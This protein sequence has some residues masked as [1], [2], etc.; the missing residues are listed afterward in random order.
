MPSVN[1]MILTINHAAE[2]MRFAIPDL[3]LVHA[4]Q[5]QFLRITNPV[6]VVRLI[7]DD[8]A[9]AVKMV[10]NFLMM[11][12]LIHI[13]IR[14]I[15]IGVLVL[16]RGHVM[17]LSQQLDCLEVGYAINHDLVVHEAGAVLQVCVHALDA[18]VAAESVVDSDFV[19]YLLNGIVLLLVAGDQI[20]LKQ[21]VPAAQD[22][23]V[24]R[25]EVVPDDQLLLLQL[26]LL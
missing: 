4:L 14:I 11:N 20:A 2:S 18:E 1:M 12:Q 3:S 17:H 25:H 10:R 22:P 24:A 6:I 16:H 21:L 19:D 8:S 7:L 9:Y 26:E 5:V 15:I 23:L 13:A